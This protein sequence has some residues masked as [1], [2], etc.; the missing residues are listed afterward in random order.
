M[1]KESEE[2]AKMMEDAV[3]YLRT[4]EVAESMAWHDLCYMLQRIL[5]ATVE[6]PR[7]T[8]KKW[9]GLAP[10]FCECGS[11]VIAAG[12]ST[13]AKEGEEIEVVVT[14]WVCPACLVRDTTKALEEE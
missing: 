13:P 6:P 7:D 3:R 2:Y 4:V 11:Q 10:F 5:E 8:A 9:S 14:E 1:L 12:Y